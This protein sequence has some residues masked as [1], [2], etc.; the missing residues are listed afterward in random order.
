L[1][2]RKCEKARPDLRVLKEYKKC[3]EESLNCAK[4]LDALGKRYGVIMPMN[5]EVAWTYY[6]PGRL[7]SS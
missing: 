1:P 3:K 2:D 5:S 4:D 6:F 7:S